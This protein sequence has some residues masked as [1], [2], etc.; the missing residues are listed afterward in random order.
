VGGKRKDCIVKMR[1]VASIALVMMSFFTFAHSIII[2]STTAIS[3]QGAAT[4]PTADSDNEMRGFAA[5]EAGFTL[6]DVATTATFNA[7]FPVGSDVTFNNGS[8]YL[9]QDLTLASDFRMMDGGTIYGENRSIIFPRTHSI[10]L[11]IT[12]DDLLFDNLSAYFCSDVVLA[13]DIKFQGTSFLD[14]GGN[15]LDLNMH[16]IIVESGGS[17][18]IKNTTIKGISGTLIRCMDSATTLSLDNVRWVQDGVYTM[19][20]GSI[21][22]LHHVTLTGTGTFAYQSANPSTIHS[23][24]LLE[25]DYELTF[26]YDPLIADNDL[27]VMTDVSS[28]LYLNNCTLFSTPTGLHLQKGTLLIDGKVTI[29]SEAVKKAEAIWCGDGVSSENDTNIEVMPAAT[30]DIESGYIVYKN[31]A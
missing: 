15:T 13:G 18:L 30:I 29:Q 20:E 28:L 3:R 4:F 25:V 11:P 31:V 6:D 19:T 9:E 16:S 27:L 24:S 1:S 26:S 8:L 2:G 5:F 17:L 22:I 10:S 23:N 7:Y 21:E 14:G 12:A